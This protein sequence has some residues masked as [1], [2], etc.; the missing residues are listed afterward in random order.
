M[1]LFGRIKRVMHLE[2]GDS[3]PVPGML[4][5]LLQFCRQAP[6][7]TQQEL[8]QGTGRDKGQVARMV[9]DLLDKGMLQREDHP[10]DKRSHC[11]RLTPTGEAAVELFVR[12]E[13]TVAKR[14]FSDMNVTERKVLMEQVSALR[15][16]IDQHLLQGGMS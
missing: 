10:I 11:L 2:L 14:L 16:R 4:M 13:V 5:R 1:S 8:A 6:G 7:I 9:K 12:A 15:R 3:M